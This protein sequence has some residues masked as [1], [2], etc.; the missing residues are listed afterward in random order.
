VDDQIDFPKELSVIKEVTGDP[1]YR[2][3]SLARRRPE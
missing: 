1:D 2:N 3:A